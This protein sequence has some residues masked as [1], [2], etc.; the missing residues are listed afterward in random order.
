[1]TNVTFNISASLL[2][3]ERPS[4]QSDFQDTYVFIYARPDTHQYISDSRAV[5]LA[6]QGV[7]LLLQ[8]HGTWG[9]MERVAEAS[10]YHVLRVHETAFP[11]SREVAR[12][13]DKGLK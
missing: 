12:V 8:L 9:Y 11:A 10:S 3:T 6:P 5:V 1:M 7:D 4:V 2:G 13:M